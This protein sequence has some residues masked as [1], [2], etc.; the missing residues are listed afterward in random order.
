M[1]LLVECLVEHIKP[2]HNLKSLHMTL[3]FMR[4]W[5]RENS[6]RMISLPQSTEEEK[7]IQSLGT[8]YRR[9]KRIQDFSLIFERDI[10]SVFHCFLQRFEMLPRLQRLE[11]GHLDLST[12]EN[13]SKVNRK[14]EYFTFAAYCP[15]SEY[16][17]K[18]YLVDAEGIR[19]KWI[20][21]KMEKFS[22]ALEIIRHSKFTFT[23]SKLI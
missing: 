1:P 10:H 16:F 4:P 17:S 22:E 18:D 15:L 20:M 19:M 7:L 5:I 12:F 23:Q 14:S 3:V 6:V 9:L 8:Q 21:T 11:L 2:M 13:F